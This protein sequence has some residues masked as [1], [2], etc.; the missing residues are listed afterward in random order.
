[1][2]TSPLAFKG[3]ALFTPGG[4]VIYCI[5]PHKQKRWHMHLCGAL[6]HWLGLAEP[7]HFLVPCYTATIDRILDPNTQ[8]LLDLAEASPLVLRYQPLLNALFQTK[9]LVWHPAPLHP[10]VCDP[11][12]L[13]THR[14][15]FPQLWDAHDLVVRYEQPIATPTAPP[16][17]LIPSSKSSNPATQGYVFRLFVS[18]H[19]MVT[20]RTMQKLHQLLEETLTQPYTLKVLDVSQH[21]EQAELDHVTAT[22]TLVRA[23]PLPS[24]RIVG[25]FDNVDQLLGVLNSL[26]E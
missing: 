20:Q 1:M 7:P 19:S 15:Q 14:S 4:D 9:G 18:G 10:E 22:P 21:P 24:R 11:M 8:Q 12:V 3:I 5:D 6:Q 16:A 23:F 2:A 26:N 25:S 17:S 13:A